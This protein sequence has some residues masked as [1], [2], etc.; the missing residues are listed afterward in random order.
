MVVV[1]VAAEA[2]DTGLLPSL[3]ALCILL[4]LHTGREE[5]YCK[6]TEQFLCPRS[7]GK[8]FKCT[9]RGAGSEETEL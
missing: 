8:P 4:Q 3:A 1:V 6:N 9:L 5:A 2:V 7:T